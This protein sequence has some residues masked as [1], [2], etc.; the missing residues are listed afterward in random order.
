M[1]QLGKAI[2][3]RLTEDDAVS[4]LVGTRVF[5]ELSPEQ[6]EYPVIIYSIGKTDEGDHYGG[7]SDTTMSR[8]N[9]I[10][11]ASS[12]EQATTLAQLIEAGGITVQGSWAESNEE[13]IIA[14]GDAVS[15][16]FHIIDTEYLIAWVEESA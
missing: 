3:S 8:C 10:A 2:F 9:I 7:S 16:R 1:S 11:V 6:D 4:A 14:I 15:D 5:P 12:Y 13:E